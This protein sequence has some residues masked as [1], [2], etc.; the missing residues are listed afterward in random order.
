MLIGRNAKCMMTHLSIPADDALQNTLSF[1][2]KKWRLGMVVLPC[3][4][5]EMWPFPISLNHFQCSF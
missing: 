3:W 5:M 2:E 4:D 1:F